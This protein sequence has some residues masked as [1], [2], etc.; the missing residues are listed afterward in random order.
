MKKTIVA[1]SMLAV[2][3]ITVGCYNV[4]T[5]VRDTQVKMVDMNAPSF[6]KPLV[7]ELLIKKGIDGESSIRD[8]WNF[9]EEE[10]I[11]LN[12]DVD[13][14][15]NRAAFLSTQKHLCDVIVSPMF[16]VYVADGKATVT[17]SGYPAVYVNF[18]TMEDKDTTWLQVTSGYRPIQSNHS[19]R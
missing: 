13:K 15:K 6:V 9:T 3:L 11:S 10:V 19:N 7:A 14:L 2:I 4:S 8:Q 16:D 1:L 5:V 17:V 12:N 18:R